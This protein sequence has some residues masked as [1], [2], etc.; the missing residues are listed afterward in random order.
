MVSLALGV[1]ISGR[2]SN[3]MAIL[4]A[5]QRGSL[6]ATVKVVASNKL[7]AAGL[8]RAKERG[9]PTVY[10]DPKPFAQKANPREAYD[11]A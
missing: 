10:L 11:V 8:E 3:L 9:L 5:I 2:G 7:N 4:D 1:L 6:D